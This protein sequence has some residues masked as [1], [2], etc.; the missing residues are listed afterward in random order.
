M[1][2]MSVDPFVRSAI[3]QQGAFMT[4]LLHDP[5][6]MVLKGHATR[7]Q[8]YEREIDPN[9][10]LALSDPRE[11]QRRI[12]LRVK[13]E[14]AKMRLGKLDPERAEIERFFIH[15]QLHEIAPKTYPAPTPPT[16]LTERLADRL[17]DTV[18]A[19]KKEA[20]PGGTETASIAQLSGETDKSPNS[21]AAIVA[22]RNNA[23]RVALEISTTDSAPRR[24]RKSQKGKKAAA[25]DGDAIQARA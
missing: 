16:A 10:K 9:G 25:N 3:A 5:H 6:E 20:A 2:S 22:R 1:T 12:D 11:L 17:R 8:R 24:G 4:N 14:A 18:Q 13:L 23:T 15:K 21:G 7:K 19:R